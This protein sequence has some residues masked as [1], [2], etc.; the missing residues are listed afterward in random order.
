MYFIVNDVETSGRHRWYHD[1]ISCGLVVLDDGLNVIDKFYEECCPW[2][3]KSF[4]ERTVEFHG[5]TIPYLRR[6]QSSESM[7]INI[8]HFLNKYRDQDR[9]V[10]RPFLYHAINKFD[11]LLMENL[12]LKN[13][14]E[15]SFR[16]MFHGQQAFSTIFLARQMGYATNG[17][18]VWA[19]R[20]GSR[21]SQ[22][23]R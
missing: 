11:F 3:L 15:F 22:R 12:F 18:D 2:Y 17:L 16:K 20:I 1:V 8:L 13:N 6:Q 23:F 10:Y 21:F 19:E 14:L 7:C 4:D 5:M 9:I